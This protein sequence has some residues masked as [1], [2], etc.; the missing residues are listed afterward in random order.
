MRFQSFIL[1]LASLAIA[2]TVGPSSARAQRARVS[3]RQPSRRGT[4]GLS[5]VAIYRLQSMGHHVRL[6]PTLQWR[7]GYS[8]YSNSPAAPRTSPARTASAAQGLG[9]YYRTPARP[10]KP[11]S[12]IQRPP[13]GF[14]RYWPLL[15][16]GRENPR[17]GVI[18]WSMP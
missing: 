18:F 1:L 5:D 12:D 4:V 3:E 17:T 10:R 16:E 15:L 2:M 13:T 9:T 8:P 14:E 11:F 7:L 6:S